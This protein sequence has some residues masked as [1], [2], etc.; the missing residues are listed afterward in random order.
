PATPP[1]RSDP[2]PPE[3]PSREAIQVTARQPG[4]VDIAVTS[5]RPATIVVLQSYDTGWIAR[6][7]GSRAHIDPA[8]IL[9]QSVQVPGGHH[10]VALRYEPPSVALGAAM[11]A[12]G[13]LALALIAAIAGWP[14]RPHR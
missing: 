1:S 7:D 14:R 10:R 3:G 6:I 12:A 8:D 13:L 11:T 4:T 5:A 9:F 2:T